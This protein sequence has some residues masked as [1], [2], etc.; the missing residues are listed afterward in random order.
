MT[1]TCLT[2]S[3]SESP[4][5]TSVSL[6]GADEARPRRRLVPNADPIFTL[7]IQL[8]LLTLCQGVSVAD[9]GCNNPAER[10]ATSSLDTEEL[11]ADWCTTRPPQDGT[12]ARVTVEWQPPELDPL[13]NVCTLRG[14]LVVPGAESN[15]NRPITWCQGVSVY[16][17]MKPGIQLDWSRGVLLVNTIEDTVI[18]ESDGQFTAHFRLSRTGRCDSKV[19]SFQAGVSLAHHELV[20]GRHKVTWN[21]S[22]PVIASS[23]RRLTVPATELSKELRLINRARGWPFQNPDGVALI[24]AVNALQRLGKDK[25]LK[26]MEQYLASLSEHSDWTDGDI[27]FWIIRLLFEPVELDGRIPYPAIAVY[28]D[29]DPAGNWPLNPIAVVDGIPFMVGHQIGMGGLP[30]QPQS[31]IE[32]ARRHGVI[33]D[34][35]LTPESDPVTA[36]DRLINSPRFQLLDDYELSDGASSVRLQALAMIDD[37]IDP[38]VR[39]VSY[40]LSEGKWSQ[41]RQ[42]TAECRIRWNRQQQTFVSE[43]AAGETR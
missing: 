31:H 7:L 29:E 35:P 32:W 14:Q 33:R 26:V 20:N 36:A 13:G 21:S 28:L 38:P 3:G 41:V 2:N 40:R 11:E 9:D 27:V 23:V 8:M 24:R 22:T 6:V 43:G 12:L 10:N 1:P 17:A 30:E 16:L 5:R 37:V 19:Q 42:R 4:R 25:A 18:A 34:E 39:R 15:R